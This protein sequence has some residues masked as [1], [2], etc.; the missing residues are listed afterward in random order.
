MEALG[1]LAGGVAHDLNNILSGVV[2]YP[3]LLLMDLPPES[4]LK[5]PLLTI[6]GSGE[7]AARIV[8]DLLTLARRGVATTEAVN[9]NTVVRD[10]LESPECRKLL[11]HHPTV[12]VESV[13]AP[14]LGNVMGSA[15]HLSK[16][17]MNLVSNAAEAMPGGGRVAIRTENRTLEAPVR[18]YEEV[19]AGQYA[20]LSVADQGLGI[21]PEEIDRI[22][23]PF[24]TK[25]VMGRSGTGLGMAVVWGTVKDHRGY[26]DVESREEAG[27]VFTLYLPATRASVRPGTGPAALDELMGRGERILVVDDVVEQREIASRMLRRLGYAVETVPS[28]EAALEHLRQRTAD[29]VILDMIMEPGIDGLETFRRMRKI[30]PG[31]RAVITSGYSETQRVKATQSEGASG[32]LRKPYSLEQMA[33][34]VH[35]AL[36][37]PGP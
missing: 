8:Q 16:T 4:P 25:K 22:F 32:Y 28:G 27:T 19:E 34:A 5:K 17:V 26:I 6:K 3:E 33:R 13:L 31:Q 23:E 37:N 11:D 35:S 2:T 10:Y 15:V 18:G 36:G 1:T 9:V 20:V 29:L 24:Y 14:D 21:S 7:K 12:R 30:R